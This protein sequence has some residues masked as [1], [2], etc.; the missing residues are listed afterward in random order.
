MTSLAYQDIVLLVIIGALGSLV[1]LISWVQNTG[2]AKQKEILGGVVDFPVANS[3]YYRL[4]C[5]YFD[6]VKAVRL[7][8]GYVPPIL[9]L[10]SLISFCG[11]VAYFAP[12]WTHYLGTPSY[13]LG[14]T[15]IL[16]A[17]SSPEIGVYQSGTVLMGTMAFVGAYVYILRELISRINNNDISPITY[18]Y[19]CIRI[20]TAT[21]VAGVVRHALA[22]LDPGASTGGEITVVVGFVVGLQPDLWVAFAISKVSKRFGLLG[23]QA[24]PAQANVPSNGS[25]LLIVGLSEDKRTRLEE[26]NIDSCQALAAH[27]PFIIW[28][29]TSYQ[30]L[31]IVDWMA[32]AQLAERVGDV[33]LMR[34]RQIGV[35][36]IFALVQVWSG[37]SVAQVANQ[38]PQMTPEIATDLLLYIQGSPDFKRLKEVYQLIGD[39][40]ASQKK[41][42][43]SAWPA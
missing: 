37:A 6:Q 28:A 16:A 3:S 31:H 8:G 5:N 1:L 11:S 32:Q 24:D 39:D 36:N 34:L 41:A 19:F 38:I 9:F 22:F 30:L 18:Y 42:A 27:N 29:R 21:M 13:I 17:H 43:P 25:L 15:F 23:E 33:G 40:A 26:L 4:A 12:Q 2:V 20:I 10:F 14:G 7:G 35:C